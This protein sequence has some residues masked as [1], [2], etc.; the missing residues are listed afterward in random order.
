MNTHKPSHIQ[1]MDIPL[2]DIQPAR[3]HG[4]RDRVVEVH[5]HAT[6]FSNS[7][8]DSSMKGEIAGSKS[9]DESMF[10]FSKKLL[11]KPVLTSV[12]KWYSRAR[13]LMRVPKSSDDGSVRYDPMRFGIASWGKGSV[14]VPVGR[15]QDLIAKFA[16]YK[17][18]LRNEI[19]SL[20]PKWNDLM[21]DAE[22]AS[23]E[24]FDADLMPSFDEFAGSWEMNLTITALP[25]YD[26]RITLDDIQLEDVVKQ[27]KDNTAQKLTEHLSGAWKQAAQSM[28]TSL[29]Y[30]A[31]VLANDSAAVMALNG[32]GGKRKSKRA[33]PIADTLFDNLR[34]QIITTRALAEAAQDQG[35]KD[36]VDKVAAT[37][38]SCTAEHLRANPTHRDK[39]AQTAKQLVTEARSQ[40]VNTAT[41]INSAIDELAA[42][43]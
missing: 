14:L 11:T 2:E 15:L 22:E 19:E 39:M 34:N 17:G 16:E 13:D 31:G 25:A 9:A 12:Q 40:V 6:R 8:S 28:L 20:R 43:G 1:V 4:I 7:K 35:L 5:I 37:L 26:P 36:L 33:V 29:E 42:F 3:M 24:L 30:T 32:T 21:R 10:S 41:E 38:G 18:E 23:G 27:V